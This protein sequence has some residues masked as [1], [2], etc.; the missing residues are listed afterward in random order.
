MKKSFLLLSLSLSFF[1]FSQNYSDKVGI[2]TDEP[3]EKLHVNGTMQTDEI[4]LDIPLEKVG[5]NEEYTFLIK[6]PGSNKIMTYDTL[7]D[8]SG[9][10]TAPLNLIQFEISTDPEDKDWI[11]VYDTKINS[12]KYIA[13]ISSFGFNMSVSGTRS[14]G[15]IH[16]IYTYSENGT[17]KIKADYDGFKPGDT[18]TGKWKLNL[19]VFDRNYANLVPEKTINM[20]GNDSGSGILLN[21]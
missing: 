17:W 11:N 13:I 14:Y 7:F 1:A 6:M 4:K 15:P 16:Q 19:L 20:N 2:N 3:I 8:T 21:I 9:T 18:G 5:N 10:N 12:N